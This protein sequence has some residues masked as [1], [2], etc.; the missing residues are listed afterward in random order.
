MQVYVSPRPGSIPKTPFGR[1][2]AALRES[3]SYMLYRAHVR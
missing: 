1:F 2:L 3:F